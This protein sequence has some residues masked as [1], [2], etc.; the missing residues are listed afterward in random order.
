MDR[1]QLDTNARL[2]YHCHA[3]AG[4]LSYQVI[5]PT[6]LFLNLPDLRTTVVPRIP[7]SAGHP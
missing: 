2:T 5:N 6:D 4:D 7:T 1:W 3:V